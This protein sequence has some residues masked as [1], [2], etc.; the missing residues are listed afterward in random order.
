MRLLLSSALF[1]SLQNSKGYSESKYR[2]LNVFYLLVDIALEL[3]RDVLDNGFALLPNMRVDGR[4]RRSGMP[5]VW[6]LHS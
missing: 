5:H 2:I 3:G 6:Y 4:G 1:L